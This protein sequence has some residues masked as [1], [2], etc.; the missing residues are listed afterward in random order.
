MIVYL[1]LNLFNTLVVFIFSLCPVFETPAWLITYLPEILTT[2]FSFNLYLPIFET[3]GV[4][5]FLIFFTI[6]Y[7]VFRIVLN[8]AGIDL[9][10]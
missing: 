9:S 6:Q 1:L 7:K 3:A 10:K 4:V 2:I 8:K 5:T